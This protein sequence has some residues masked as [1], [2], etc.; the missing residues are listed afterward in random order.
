MASYFFL[1]YLMFKNLISSS[2][3][4]LRPDPVLSG[5]Q[6]YIFGDRCNLM[7][8]AFLEA[9]QVGGSAP[10]E[11]WTAEFVGLFVVMKGEARL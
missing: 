5:H 2:S 1:I 7:P 6:R 4:F 8:T 11:I 3:S 10:W 9:E